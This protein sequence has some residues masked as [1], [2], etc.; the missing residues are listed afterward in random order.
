VKD[1]VKGRTNSS[2]QV[3]ALAGVS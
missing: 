1:L 2:V 3:N